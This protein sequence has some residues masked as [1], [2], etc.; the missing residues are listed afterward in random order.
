MLP[1][2]FFAFLGRWHRGELAVA[3]QDGVMDPAAAHALFDAPD[4]LAAFCRGPVLWGTLAGDPQ[5][6]AA[7][8]EADGRVQSFIK[9]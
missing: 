2:L 7:V 8:R 5:L 3:Y 9:G 6:E 1:A 4:P